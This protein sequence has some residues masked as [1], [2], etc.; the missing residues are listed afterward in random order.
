ML[1]SA[2]LEEGNRVLDL[3]SGAGSQTLAAANRVGK[4]G[5]VVANDISQTMLEFVK[6][7]AAASGLTNVETLLGSAL[8][9]DFESEGFESVISRFGLMLMPE[10]VKVLSKVFAALKPGGKVSVAVFSL[11]QANEFM[12]VPMQILLKHA[13]KSPPPPGAPGIFSLAAPGLLEKLFTEAGFE[14][15][16]VES[17]DIVFRLPPAEQALVMMQ[18]AFG[19]YRAVVSDCSDE[20][21]AAAWAEVLEYLRTIDTGDGVNAPGQVLV[22]SAG[23]P[24][25]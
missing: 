16:G 15:P 19:A 10:P 25:N 7:N 1:N 21:K 17:V 3:A 14:N 20:T 2:G 13:G 11:P 8:E 9:L 24:G 22:G 18:E 4:S 5:Q 12:A 23:K 6:K